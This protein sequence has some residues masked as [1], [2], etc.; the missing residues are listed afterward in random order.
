M[1]KSLFAILGLMA[2]SSMVFAAVDINTANEKDLSMVKGIGPVKAKSIVEYR[3][4][5]GTFKDVHELGKV[6]GFSPKT[7][8]KLSKNLSVTEVAAPAATTTAPAATKQK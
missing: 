6:P 1:K 2:L 5:H 7:V 3:A 8:A 4:Q